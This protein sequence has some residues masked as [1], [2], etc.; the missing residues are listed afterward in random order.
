MPDIELATGGTAEGKTYAVGFWDSQT[1][2]NSLAEFPSDIDPSWG[3]LGLEI[4]GVDAENYV[5][6]VILSTTRDLL[7]SFRFT[8]PG[9]KRIDLSQY[10]Q[11]TSTQD[12]IVR[13]QLTTFV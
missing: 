3:I 7:I 1:C 6:V 13:I 4:D 5:E 11:I 9:K 8:T 10:S 12:V 2:D